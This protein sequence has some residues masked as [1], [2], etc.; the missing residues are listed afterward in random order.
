[1]DTK[2]KLTVYGFTIAVLFIVLIS[3]VLMLKGINR[4]QNEGSVVG[5]ARPLD[6]EH[7][8]S[9]EGNISIGSGG[10]G[11]E[12][13]VGDGAFKGSDILFISAPQLAL[14]ESENGPLFGIRRSENEGN[15]MYQIFAD[16]TDNGA[17]L[18]LIGEYL[19]IPPYLAF[20]VQEQL[21]GE[22]MAFEWNETTFVLMR[23]YNE[24][25]RI[26]HRLYEINN[27]DSEDIN[28]ADNEIVWHGCL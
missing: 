11:Q 3:A 20:P 14:P 4:Q 12:R 17:K 10:P 2:R 26:C 7:I 18:E 24:E 19:P 28:E 8:L 1:M 22:Y 21:E 27:L 9:D 15:V 13:G 23:W 6:L 25:G 16:G 5:V